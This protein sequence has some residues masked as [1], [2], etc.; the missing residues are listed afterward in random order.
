M[1]VACIMALEKETAS[2][3]ERTHAFAATR[4]G[5]PARPTCLKLSRVRRA[6]FFVAVESGWM[7]KTLPWCGWRQSPRR[8]PLSGPRKQKL[9]SSI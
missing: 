7:D 3:K 5:R 4:L 1:N 9:C 8:I 2:V 6:N